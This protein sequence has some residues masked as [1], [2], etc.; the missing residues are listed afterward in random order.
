MTVHT[1][2]CPG[3]CEGQRPNLAEYL[4]LGYAPQ[5]TCHCWGGA[6][7][8]LE[9]A[10]ADF[11]LADWARRLGRDREHDVLMPR[12]GWWRNT[13]NPSAGQEGGY[14]QAR[15]ADGTWLWPFS[16]TSD[17]GFAQGTSATYTWT[18][19][20]RRSRSPAPRRRTSRSS[21]SRPA[22]DQA[23]RTGAELERAR[24]G[25]QVA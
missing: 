25:Q 6:A 5:D 20:A 22:R 13:F 1:K 14:Q 23:G 12:A 9:D 15:K 24:A 8:T 3:Q 4:R 11:A 10:T 2:G 17:A 21:H 7:E 18:R 19:P 16:A